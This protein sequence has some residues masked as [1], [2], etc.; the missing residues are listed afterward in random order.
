M[1][2]IK[3]VATDISAVVRETFFLRGGIIVGQYIHAT[4]LE[5]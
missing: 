3:I 5:V 2:S 1:I 4:K